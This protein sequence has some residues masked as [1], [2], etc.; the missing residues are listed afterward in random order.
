MI[1]N[2]LII[3]ANYPSIHTYIRYYSNNDAYN[4]VGFVL[5]KRNSEIQSTY[6]RFKIT[7]TLKYPVY[8]LEELENVIKSNEVKKCLI[9]PVG[10]SCSE[11]DVIVNRIYSTGICYTEFPFN[12][13]SS[14]L[15]TKKYVCCISSYEDG[16]DHYPV[17]EYIAK[18][19][20]LRERLRVST[21]VP[22]MDLVEE[23]SVIDVYKSPHYEI[24]DENFDFNLLPPE[25]R[26]IAKNCAKLKPE[27]L[28][29]SSDL[30]KSIILAEQK[31]DTIIVSPLKNICYG[32]EKHLYLNVFSSWNVIPGKNLKSD[33]GKLIWPVI[34]YSKQDSCIVYSAMGSSNG[35]ESNKIEKSDDNND[36]RILHVFKAKSTLNIP[37]PIPSIRVMHLDSVNMNEPISCDVNIYDESDRLLNLL[38][39]NINV[40]R[41]PTLIKHFENLVDIISSVLRS[42]RDEIYVSNNHGLNK[43]MLAKIVIQSHIPPGFII[44]NGEIIDSSGLK[45]RKLDLVIVNKHY[46]SIRIDEDRQL[47][48]PILPNSVLSVVE[49]NTRLSEESLKKSLN[50]LRPVKSFNLDIKKKNSTE[51]EDSSMGE[52]ILTGVF[53][54]FQENSVD[55]ESILRSYPDV[56]DFIIT[57]EKTSYFRKKVLEFCKIHVTD[58]KE[59]FGY[60]EIT[61]SGLS[62]ALMFAVLNYFA[63][64]REKQ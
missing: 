6:R 47:A 21:I 4:C 56:V 14:L 10:I 9:M 37:D 30:N 58:L 16:L 51:D 33:I 15:N 42:T 35:S 32:I 7:N 41:E 45:T 38:V 59:K 36:N 40:N 52:K 39:R 34:D 64:F 20:I 29:V 63:A 25:Y 44:L 53:S 26:E 5:C 46:P 12:D 24:K 31:T 49:V 43:E 27:V 57:H 23:K 61:K 11:V 3:G 60:Y 54:F 1:E 48:A 17:T 2:V 22:I 18:I 62:L 55:L 28:F 8:Q 50:S 13:S 19:L